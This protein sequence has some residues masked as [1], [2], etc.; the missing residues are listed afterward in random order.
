MKGTTKI[1]AVLLF[2]FAAIQ[3]NAQNAYKFGHIDSQKLLQSLPE[4]AEAQKALE[5]EGKSIQDQLETMQVEYNNKVNDYV[6]ND[7][8][9]VGEAKK[10]SNIVKSD[11]EKEIQNLGKRVQE[12][13]MTAQ[14]Q[15]Q[16][17]RAELF[18]PI[19]EKVDKAIKDVASENKFTYIFDISVLL[20]HSDDSIDIT[21]MVK[22]KLTVK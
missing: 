12:F 5:A 17:K 9:P 4:S 20:Y 18:K 14:E 10:W 2:I 1:L 16:N 22:A 6:E 13:Q 11:K 15:I 8:L 3:V 7:K 19:L 21:S